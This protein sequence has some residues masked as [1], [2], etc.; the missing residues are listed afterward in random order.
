M[1]ITSQQGR[2][3]Q[4]LQADAS[5]AQE[6]LAEKLGCSRSVVG[7]E[8]KALEDAGVIQRRTIVVDAHKVGLSTTVYMLIVLDAHG[9]GQAEKFEQAVRECFPNVIEMAHIQGEWDLLL[10]I[11]VRDNEHLEEIQRKLQKTPNVRR[12]RSYGSLGVPKLYP[13]PLDAIVLGR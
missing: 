12:T 10:K 9:A 6:L 13:L 2:L 5:M 4:L 11:V 8:L 7:R 1:K 3:L